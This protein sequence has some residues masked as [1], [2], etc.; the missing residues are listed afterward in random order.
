MPK[1]IFTTP[2]FALSYILPSVLFTPVDFVIFVYQYNI[3]SFGLCNRSGKELNKQTTV[4]TDN[5]TDAGVDFII[6]FY[7]SL[8]P[9]LHFCASTVLSF[10]R[11][12]IVQ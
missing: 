2:Y 12:S 10:S 4:L 8:T 3:V 6:V 11:T 7:T 9:F 5:N 1:L